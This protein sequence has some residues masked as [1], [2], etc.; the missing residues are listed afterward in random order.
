[1]FGGIPGPIQVRRLLNTQPQNSRTGRFCGYTSAKHM[2]DK[3]V[4]IAMT[5]DHETGDP[6]SSNASSQDTSSATIEER[7]QDDAPAASDA[8]LGAVDGETS[9]IVPPM[10]ESSNAEIDPADEITPG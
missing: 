9:A 5:S 6:R 7:A 8:H 4:F 3:G 1:M 2:H 10:R